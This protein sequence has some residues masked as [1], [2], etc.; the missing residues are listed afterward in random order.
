VKIPPLDTFS[1]RLPKLRAK[2]AELHV[3]K[4][5]K[6]AECAVLVARMQDAPDP[7]NAH[8]RRVAEILDEKPVA[9]ELPATDQ[10]RAKRQ[11]I[12]AI[13]AAISTLDAEI[14]KETRV[15]NNTLLKSVAP[16]ITRLG[17]EFAKAFLATRDKHLAFNEFCDSIEDAGGNVSAIRIT[18]NGLSDPRDRCGNYSYAL[19]EFAEAGFVSH[20]VV[21]KAI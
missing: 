15:A 6:T 21:P 14:Q 19:R 10:L 4:T 11:E 13:N 20:S 12:E 1:L 8:A 3:E 2:R 5:R 18:P 7:G 16:E 17:T 9:V